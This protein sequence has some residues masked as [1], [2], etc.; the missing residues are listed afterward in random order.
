MIKQITVCDKCHKEFMGI[1]L[2]KNIDETAISII[3]GT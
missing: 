2:H 1:Y 3:R